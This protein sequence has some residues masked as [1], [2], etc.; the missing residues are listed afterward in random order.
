MARGSWQLLP[1]LQ[2]GRGNPA[3]AALNGRLYAIGGYPTEAGALTS[4]EVI[5]PGR[6]QA[7]SRVADLPDP[8][9]RGSGA[10]AATRDRIYVTGGDDGTATAVPLDSLVVYDPRANQWQYR[11][12][13]LTARSNLKL[14][15]LDPYIYAIGG[16]ATAAALNTVER[17]DPR[18]DTWTTVA[19][20][21]S[22]RV[23][24]A[25]AVV[26]RQIVVVGGSDGPNFAGLQPLRTSEVYS[27]DTDSWTMLEPLLD[28]G[29]SGM[30]S[31]AVQGH[32][33]L[34]IGGV[35][36]T[37]Q[38]FVVTQRVDRSPRIQH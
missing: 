21:K 22:A 27:P 1:K 13:M 6:D 12:R 32:R 15:Y 28:P 16:I 23:N 24:P 37:D 19:P 3:A 11:T 26:G 31:A 35:F 10:A 8:R 4:V 20:M 14:I 30:T 34:A 18:S 5:E 36:L 17:Y 9:G 25:P 38:G 2:Y 29:R 33:V 7:W